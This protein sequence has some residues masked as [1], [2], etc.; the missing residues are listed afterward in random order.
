MG[1]TTAVNRQAPR[2]TGRR[3]VQQARFHAY[4]PRVFAYTLGV[5]GD[6]ESA[7]DLTAATF[8]E[9]FALPDMRDPEFAIEIFR[10]ARAL[11]RDAGSARAA[12]GDGLTGRERDVLSLVFDARLPRDEVARMLSLKPETV[13]GVLLK[14][15]R[16][17]QD[18]LPAGAAPA[19]LGSLTPAA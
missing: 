3:E 1:S 13:L 12:I 7:G 11:A 4:F 10:I 6:E 8:E 2:V 9:A 15:L 18:P 17:L 5:T 16:K 14:G 19:P